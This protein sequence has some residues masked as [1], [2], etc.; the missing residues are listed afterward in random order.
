MRRLLKPT[1][2]RIALAHLTRSVMEEL[3]DAARTIGAY[4]G[5]A[6]YCGLSTGHGW[7]VDRDGVRFTASGPGPDLIVAEVL[8][9]G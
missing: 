8:E 1:R 2:E 4:S 5:V 3:H 6:A 9:R 7:L